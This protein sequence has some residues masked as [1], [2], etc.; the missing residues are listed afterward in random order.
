M[1]VSVW[2]GFHYAKAIIQLAEEAGLQYEIGTTQELG[3][4]TAAQAHLG[5]SMRN[6]PYICDP[7]GPVVYPKDVVEP[8]LRFEDGFM[9]IPTGLGLGVNLDRTKLAHLLVETAGEKVYP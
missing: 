8:P 5:A 9:H 4:A 6:M 1:N 7:C 2:N 3:I